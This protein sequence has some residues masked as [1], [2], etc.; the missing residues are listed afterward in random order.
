MSWLNGC[1]L[2]YHKS[3]KP[4]CS[5]QNGKAIHPKYTYIPIPLLSAYGYFVKPTTKIAWFKPKNYK[6]A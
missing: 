6:M 1:G 2:F 5:W 4:R 3:W